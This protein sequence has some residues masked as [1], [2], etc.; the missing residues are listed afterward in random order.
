[1]TADEMIARI[2]SHMLVAE[3]QE[4]AGA[5]A[6]RSADPSAHPYNIA[7]LPVIDW[8]FGKAERS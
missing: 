8:Y 3:D 5:V 6:I 1:M 4:I 2:E 7:M